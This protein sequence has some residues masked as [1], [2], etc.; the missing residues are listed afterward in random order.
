[1]AVPALPALDLVPLLDRGLVQFTLMLRVGAFLSAAPLFGAR[2]VPVQVRIVMAFA[3][4][5][6]LSGH[7][8]LPP[9]DRIA[10]L[11]A[12]PML[13]GEVALG[14]VAG[15]VLTIL[16]SAAAMA[17]DRIA[18]TAGLGFAAQ[19]DPTA[20]AQTPVVSQLFTFGLL[21]IFV[22]TDAHLRVIQILLDSYIRRPPG[23]PLAPGLL[24]AGIE[25]GGRLFLLGLGLA[26][27]VMGLLVLL[28]LAVGVLTRS[29]PQFNIF[30]FGFP[31]TMGATLL[32]LFVSAPRMGA[33][34]EALVSTA[35]AAMEFTLEAPDGR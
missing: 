28:N 30:S 5:L 1:M 8:P 9:P 19:F 7:V 14:L 15:S 33:G 18:N 31:L 29:A 26:L 11:S 20:G 4:S 23:A 10:S 2:F 21:M 25:A 6:P 32:M 17:G 16:F 27:P 3:L 24:L 34:F 22:T 12:V 35:L 13:L